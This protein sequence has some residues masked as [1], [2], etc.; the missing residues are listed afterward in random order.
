MK[1]VGDYI[2]KEKIGAGAFG[3]VYTATS[4]VDQRTYAIKM[5]NK[6]TMSPKARSYLTREISILRKISNEHVV[7]LHDVKMSEHNYYLVFEYCNGG[8]LREYQRIKGGR[9]NEKSVRR[10]IKQIAIGL[11]S[12]YSLGG[13]HR[14][15]KLSNILLHYPTFSSRTSDE[16]SIKVCDFGFA[17]IL[18]CAAALEL[19]T[20]GTP[21]NMS[22][23][24]IQGAQYDVSSDIWSLGVI[25]YELLFGSP[26][27]NATNKEKLIEIVLCGK[28]KLSKNVRFSTETVDFITSCI[29]HEAKNRL[30]WEDLIKHPFV[31][32]NTA[33]PFESYKLKEDNKE[34]LDEDK[35]DYLV[36]SRVKYEFERLYYA[37]IIKVEEESAAQPKP[38]DDFKLIDV[39]TEYVR[40][41]RCIDSKLLSEYVMI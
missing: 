19:S 34:E 31:S 35:G 29:Q 6:D 18:D 24:M 1:K 37:E 40:V 16:P 28:Y 12:I 11:T 41:D 36:S 5:L 20:V 26:P 23:E 14:D 13:I 8:D 27:F 17:R 2:M 32:S 38:K 9:L 7:K 25:T 33:I 15:I 30:K 10:I 22:P 39:N 3:E 4:K 21:L